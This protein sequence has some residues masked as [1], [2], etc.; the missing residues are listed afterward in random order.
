MKTYLEMCARPALFPVRFRYG[1]E[2]IKGFGPELFQQTGRADS[3]EHGIRRCCLNFLFD[4]QIVVRAE[5]EYDPEFSAYGWTVW[6]E[7]AGTED[8]KVI[9]DLVCADLVFPGG[10]PL[11]RGI[12]GD[13]INQ[14][15]PYTYDLCQ[16]DAAFRA[17]TG[18]R[19]GHKHDRHRL[20][21]N[22]GGRVPS[23]GRGNPAERLRRSG[24]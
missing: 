15:R 24:A 17:V 12:L 8:T 11:L 6:F 2:L 21:R 1:G 9:S 13:H 18:N 20:G 23:R 14:Y 4:G 16:Q 5:T 19:R 10:H 7:N 3:M 22:V